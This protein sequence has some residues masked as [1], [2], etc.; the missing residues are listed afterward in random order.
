MNRYGGMSIR[1]QARAQ[2][3]FGL[4]AAAL[5]GTSVKPRASA[6]LIHLTMRAID[7]GSALAMP[8]ASPESRAIDSRRDSARSISSGVGTASSTTFALTN[9]RLLAPA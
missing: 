6:A 8:T 4:M 1:W 2:L 7:T 9:G 5:I 3:A